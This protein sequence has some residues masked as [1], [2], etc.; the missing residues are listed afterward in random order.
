MYKG[1]ES[2]KNNKKEQKNNFSYEKII[3]CSFKSIILLSLDI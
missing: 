1:L 2:I 3:F